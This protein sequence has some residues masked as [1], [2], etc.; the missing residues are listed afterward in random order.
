MIIHLGKLDDRVLKRE[1]RELAFIVQ[2][3]TSIPKDRL[4]VPFYN[5]NDEVV[6]LSYGMRHAFSDR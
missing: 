2:R 1:I 5:Y 3:G 6:L 4:S